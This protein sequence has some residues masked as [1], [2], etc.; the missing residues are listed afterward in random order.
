MEACGADRKLDAWAKV[1]KEKEIDQIHEKS[2]TIHEKTVKTSDNSIN[3]SHRPAW[4]ALLGQA[5]AYA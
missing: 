1:N 5:V 4:R 2:T 3:D